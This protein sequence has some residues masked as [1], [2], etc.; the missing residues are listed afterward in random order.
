MGP[1]LEDGMAFGLPQ[2]STIS[3]LKDHAEF[4]T[5]PLWGVSLHGPFLHDG[6]AETLE[7]AITMHG[8]EAED[9]KNDF[10]ALPQQD[11]DDI[12]AF[13]EHL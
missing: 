5:Q 7:E 4:R 8:G 6:R 11:R 2:A 10:V 1:D 12:I 3:A 9:I 13:L